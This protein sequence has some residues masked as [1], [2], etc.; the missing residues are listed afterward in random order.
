MSQKI[1]LKAGE[2]KTITL[3]LTDDSGPVDLSSAEV[4][5]GVK[6]LKSD[7]AYI[8]SKSDADFNK[9]QASQ[10]ILEVFLSSS[11]T[12]KT[13]GLYIGELKIDF[14]GSPAVIE[15]TA[16]FHIEIQSAVT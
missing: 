8:F 10:G 13:P 1:V 11:D 2:A 14:G 7:S 9:A 5:M 16:D 15:K 4:F 3:R 6:R 12:N